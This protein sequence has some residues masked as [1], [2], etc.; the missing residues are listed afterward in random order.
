MQLAFAVIP[1]IH[2][3]SDKKEMG[4]FTIKKSTQA[5]GWI[6]VSI[7]VSLNLK[8]VFSTANEWISNS[9]SLSIKVLIV[10]V[11]L[12]IISLLIYTIIYPLIAKKIQSKPFIHPTIDLPNLSTEF[13]VFKKIA[14]ALD[15]TDTDS[16]SIKHALRLAPKDTHIILIHIVES[17]SARLLGNNAHDEETIR[18]KAILQ[19]YARFFEDRGYS[20]SAVL[21]YNKRVQEIVRIVKET[22]PDLLI[23]GSH[24]HKGLHDYLYGETINQVRHLIDIPVFIAKS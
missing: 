21:G 23:L 22:Q 20:T 10:L 13:E 4:M 14:I 19:E 12:L 2:F 3:V 1:L 15:Y 16:N 5:I 11:E 9:S 8:L 24:G 18:D 7:I 6:V 17:A